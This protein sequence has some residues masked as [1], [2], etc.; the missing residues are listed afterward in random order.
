M[1]KKPKNINGPRAGKLTEKGVKQNEWKNVMWSINI[2]IFSGVSTKQKM[3]ER[4][5]E[6]KRQTFVQTNILTDR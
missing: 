4:I 5:R 2:A 3:L 1:G 6:T